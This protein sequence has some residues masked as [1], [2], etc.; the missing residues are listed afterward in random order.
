MLGILGL[1]ISLIFIVVSVY[2]G[3]HIIP[4]SLMGGL[5]VAITNGMNIWPAISESYASGLSGYVG[6][7]FIIFILGAFFGELMSLTGSAKSI[8]YKLM[9]IMGVKRAPVALVI[10]TLILTYGGINSFIVVFALYP[11]AVV[12]FNEAK[13]PRR[14]LT[15]CIFLGLATITQSSFPGTPSIQNLI[16]ANFFNT[17]ITAAPLMGITASILFFVV[18]MLY[19][20]WQ[21]RVAR[22]NNEV[23]IPILADNLNNAKDIDIIA[24]LP[25]WK[26]AIT[27]VI[28]VIIVILLLSKRVAALY[29]VSIGLTVAIMLTYALNWKNID[30]PVGAMGKGCIAGIMPLLNT[31]AIVAYGSIVKVAPAFQEF[32]TFAMNLNFN[33]YVTGAIG[34]NIIAGITGSSSGGLT[35][36]LENMGTFLIEKGANPEALHRV[37]SIASGGLDTLPHNGAVVTILTVLGTTHKESYKDVAMVCVVLPIL[38][39][40]VSVF[41]AILLY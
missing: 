11:I 41:M 20:N 3:W 34:V 9:D 25:N 4:V 35:I 26:I 24:T 38:V 18:G 12:L 15:T 22:K 32:I 29:A 17:P 7:Y 10:A 30:D 8:A 13:L 21:I 36:F 37:L 39:T 16:P 40:V 31:S 2:K 23:F 27:P 1:I 6:S 14:I 28:T 33:E 19:I 5:F